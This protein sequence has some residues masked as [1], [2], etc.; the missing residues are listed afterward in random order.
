MN[1]RKFLRELAQIWFF[2]I[3]LGVL[4]TAV[5]LET[6]RIML[7]QVI[8]TQLCETANRL[9]RILDFFITSTGKSLCGYVSLIALVYR[10]VEQTDN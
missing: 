3:N 6:F 10:A 1:G 4:D 9:M 7:K 2:H 5:S 8:F